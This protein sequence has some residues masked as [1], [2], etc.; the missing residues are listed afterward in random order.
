MS[1]I[2]EAPWPWYIG[3]P[4]I[5]LFAPLLLFVGNR[6]FGVSSNLRHMCSILF[7]SRIEYFRYNWKQIGQWN[8]LFAL[9]IAIGGL[10]AS[11]WGGPHSI[12][13]ADFTKLALANLGL[14]DLS[15]LAPPE[16]FSWSALVTLKGFVCVILG[17][18]LVGF[19]TAYAGGCTSGHAISG[20]ANLELPSLVAVVSFFVGGMIATYFILPLIF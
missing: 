4:A 6:M 1:L 13:I 19:G 5:G 7:P 18:F 14:Y 20:L 8:L 9:G 11:Q 17:G 3:G 2:P 16:I 12:E 10:L 15:G